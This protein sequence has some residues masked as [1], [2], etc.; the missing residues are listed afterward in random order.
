MIAG[1]IIGAVVGVIV[2]LIMSSKASARP[3]YEALG[4][5]PEVREVI[6]SL[7][8]PQQIFERLRGLSATYRFEA[9]STPD[10]IL[11]RRN[12]DMGAMG[13]AFLLRVAPNGTGSRISI[14]CAPLHPSVKKV[15]PQHYKHFQNFLAGAIS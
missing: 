8:P 12:P 13:Y 14:S 2:W 7:M 1:G 6:D 4:P 15:M 10:A 11:L 5:N 9:D 3:S